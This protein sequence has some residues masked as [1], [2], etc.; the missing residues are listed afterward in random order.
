MADEELLAE[1]PAPELTLTSTP[2]IKEIETESP[3][4]FTQEELDSIVGRRLAKEQRKWERQAIAPAAPVAPL[5][6]DQFDSVEAYAAAL[7]LQKAEELV[8][9]RD[10]KQQQSVLVE[11]YHD[12]EEEARGRYND[13]EQVAYNPNLP[14]TAAMAETIQSSEVGPDMAYYL[15]VNPKEADRISKLAPF[16]QAKELGRLEA[17]LLAEPATKRVSSAPD[18]ISPAKPR[19][20]SSPTFDTTDPRSIKSMT[21]TQW[22][23]A[24]RQRQVRKFEAQKLR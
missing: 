22:I 23:D 3:K 21:A 24:E 20:T 12:R 14:I 7:A 9:Q 18:P 15:G 4:T 6:A 13:F 5:E 16:V 10:V 8:K 17:K 2:E 11:A 19:G 1:I